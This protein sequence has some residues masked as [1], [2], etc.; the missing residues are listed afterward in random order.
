LGRQ[1]TISVII[2]VFNGRRYLRQAVESVLAERVGA[3]IIVVDDGSVD[4]SLESVGDICTTTISHAKNRGIAA[5]LNSGLTAATSDYVTVLDSDDYFVPNGLRRRLEFLQSHPSERG[6]AGRPA[7]IVDEAGTELVGLPHLLHPAYVPPKRV[8]LDLFKQGQ[9]FPLLTW[10]FVLDRSLCTDVGW[11]DESLR[12][13]FDCDYLFRVLQRQDIP[14]QFEPVANRRWHADNHSLVETN[15]E[16]QLNPA[17][18]QEVI[19]VCARYGLAAGGE[20]HLWERGYQK[21][22]R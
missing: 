1:K 18:I 6:V 12:S 17:T 8:S 9:L 22:I 10:L 16:K 3:E 20:F 14:I 19:A 21:A 5:A 7:A 2:P 15:G 11:F 13:A 4:G